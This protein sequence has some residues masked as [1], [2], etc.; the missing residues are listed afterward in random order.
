MAAFFGSPKTAVKY[1]Y[2]IYQLLTVYTF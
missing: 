1:L 2:H